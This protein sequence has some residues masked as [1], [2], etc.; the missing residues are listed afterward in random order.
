MQLGQILVK[1]K[2]ISSAQLEKI[3]ALQNRS[4]RSQKLGELFMSQGLITK[5]QLNDSLLEQRWRSQGLWVID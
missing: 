1:K 5:T 2:L 3:V 4:R